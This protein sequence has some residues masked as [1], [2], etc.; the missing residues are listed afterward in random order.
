MSDADPISISIP[1][2]GSTVDSSL[3]TF[4]GTGSDGARIVVTDP[5]GTMLCTTHV[6]GHQWS[7]QSQV[8]MGDGLTAID[9]RQAVAGVKTTASATFI[10]RHDTPTPEWLTVSLLIS[11]VLLIG[12]GFAAVALLGGRVRLLKSP[13]AR[14]RRRH[15]SVPS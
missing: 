1:S 5:H 7:C 2:P 12:M 15:H 14:R 3:P 4:V 9:A 6:H 13:P 11:L 8:Q 10:V